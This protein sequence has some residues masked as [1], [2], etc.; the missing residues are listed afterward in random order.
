MMSTYELLYIVSWQSIFP[1]SF[2]KL[3]SNL[4]GGLFD[5]E[6]EASRAYDLAALKLCSEST[7]LN[8]PVR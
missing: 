8:F 1:I 4:A 5:K 7:P 6:E 2:Y 3:S